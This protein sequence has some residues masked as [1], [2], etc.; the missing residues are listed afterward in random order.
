MSFE[1]TLK[2]APTAQLWHSEGAHKSPLAKKLQ[3]LFD[4]GLS[5]LYD[6]TLTDLQRSGA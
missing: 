1:I 3:D 6:Q 5:E 4:R 2:R